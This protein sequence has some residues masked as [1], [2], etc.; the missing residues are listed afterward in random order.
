M[1]VY[2]AAFIICLI[3]SLS[4]YVTICS[5]LYYNPL[6]L[7]CSSPGVGTVMVGPPACSASKAATTSKLS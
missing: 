5:T 1:Q 2:R 4:V 3:D 7:T 6:L